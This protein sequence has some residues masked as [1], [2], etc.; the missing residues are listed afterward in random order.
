MVE[1]IDHRHPD[2]R[3]VVG[4]DRREVAG[5]RVAAQP[6]ALTPAQMDVLLPRRPG[7]IGVGPAQGVQLTAEERLT[8]DAL[9]RLLA[10]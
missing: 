10:E 9:Q 5:V 7:V 3:P 4:A 2:V 1:V 6:S 8:V